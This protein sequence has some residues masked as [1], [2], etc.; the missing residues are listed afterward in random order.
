MNKYHVIELQPYI[1]LD[2]VEQTPDRC[3]QLKVDS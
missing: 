3:V 1:I 2:H